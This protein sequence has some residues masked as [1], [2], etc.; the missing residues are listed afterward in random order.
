[1]IEALLLGLYLFVGVLMVR[2]IA[3]SGRDVSPLIAPWI[4]LS[5]PGIIAVGLIFVVSEAV[6]ERD[7]DGR[8]FSAVGRVVA[9]PQRQLGKLILYRANAPRKDR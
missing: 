8:A 6:V 9:W 1:M 4:V 7:L 2:G 3:A 5:W